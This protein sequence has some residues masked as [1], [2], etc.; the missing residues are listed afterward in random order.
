MDITLGRLTA[1]GFTTCAGDVRRR[2]RRA[3]DRRTR[4]EPAART[5]VAHLISADLFVCGLVT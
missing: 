3:A 5:G 1:L 4:P 2:R